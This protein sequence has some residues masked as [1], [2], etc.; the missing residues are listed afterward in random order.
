MFSPKKRLKV[1]HV[2]DLSKTGGV[3]VMFMQFISKI[4]S[5]DKFI[6]NGLCIKI[7]E[8]RK[9]ILEQNNIKVYSPP[10]YNYNLNFRLNI[11]NIISHEISI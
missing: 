1:L 10:N 11:I 7:T 4:I 6:A 2:V 3:E 9:K 5:L 8:D